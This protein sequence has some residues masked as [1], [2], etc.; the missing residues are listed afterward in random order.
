MWKIFKASTNDSVPERVQPFL[1]KA[2]VALMTSGDGACAL[3]ALLGHPSN[4][5]E[6]FRPNA[7]E[8]A[9]RLLGPTYDAVMERYGE[10]DLVDSI[11]ESLWSEFVIPYF[12]DRG[13]NEARIFGQNLKEM[14]P[15]FF[16]CRAYFLAR[17]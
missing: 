15:R 5:G 10:C 12:E 8:E 2:F 1:S 6:L 9:C 11:R 3:H 17:R 4:G 16:F 14:D 7:R 13:E